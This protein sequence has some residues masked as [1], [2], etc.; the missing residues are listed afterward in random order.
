M[1]L[2]IFPLPLVLF[3]GGITRLRIFEQRYLRMVKESAGESGFILT[4]HQPRLPHQTSTVGSWVKVIDFQ[5]L[6]DGMLGIDIQ[7]QNAV[8]ITDCE[9]EHDRLCRATAVERPHWPYTPHN[10]I[11]AMLGEKLN[12]LLQ[13]NDDVAQLYTQPKLT[14]AAWVCARWL[15]L[16]PLLP[17]Q[18]LM[19][20]QPENYQQAV[21]L[22]KGIL[23]SK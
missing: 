6:S 10:E 4:T 21:S 12:Q 23:L 15:E 3:P 16:L 5:T 18:K 1:K 8:D 17:Q 14:D 22:L 19:F 11:T 9:V 13:D 2:A 20:F 7:A